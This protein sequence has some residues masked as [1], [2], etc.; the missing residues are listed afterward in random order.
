[1][2]ALARRLD[3]MAADADKEA[4]RARWRRVTEAVRRLAATL[5]I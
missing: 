2:L 4:A 1:M 3:A 5:F